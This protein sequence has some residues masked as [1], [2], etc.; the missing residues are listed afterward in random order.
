ML[1]LIGQQPGPEHLSPNYRVAQWVGLQV[2]DIAAVWQPQGTKVG[3][4]GT[5][6]DTTTGPGSWRYPAEG[7][8]NTMIT[9]ASYI[10]LPLKFP[11]NEE[12]PFLEAEGILGLITGGGKWVTKQAGSSLLQEAAK[13][14]LLG[15]GGSR[16]RR[17]R[18][19]ISKDEGYVLAQPPGEN[20]WADLI[21]IN[22]TEY[23]EESAGSPIY[24]SQGGLVLNFTDG[25]P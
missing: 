20:V 24:T 16:T 1:T 7:D 23:K 18:G 19:I 4:S 13:A 2:L 9:G 10:K 14:A 15:F 6:L 3:C 8:S 21:V 22:G 12:A 5:P 25:A 17:R 11:T